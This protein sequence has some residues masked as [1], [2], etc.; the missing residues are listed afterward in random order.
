MRRRLPEGEDRPGQRQPVARIH[1]DQTPASGVARVRRHMG[2][3]AE[4]L[5]RGR[6]Q[7]VNVWRPIRGPVLDRPLALC[8]WRSLYLVYVLATYLIY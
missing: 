4:A 7:V 3:D 2:G 1:V 8:D 6:V 5:L